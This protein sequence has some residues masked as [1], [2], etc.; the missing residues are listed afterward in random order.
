MRRGGEKEKEEKVE[1]ERGKGEKE[2]DKKEKEE[3]EGGE[4]EI[5]EGVDLVTTT[6]GN[7]CTHSQHLIQHPIQYS[8]QH[9]IQHPI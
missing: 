3:M 7:F 5:K 2:G 6:Q 1:E 8:I 9:S 4:R